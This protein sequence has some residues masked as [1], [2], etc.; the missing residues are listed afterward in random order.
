MRLILCGPY[1][2]VH[3]LGRLAMTSRVFGRRYNTGTRLISRGH[4]CGLSLIEEVIRIRCNKIEVNGIAL[5]LSPSQSVWKRLLCLTESTAAGLVLENNNT[6]IVSSRTNPDT[7]IVPHGITSIGVGAF[8]RD[9][10]CSELTRV[11]LS[12]TVTTIGMDAFTNCR[13]L[14]YFIQSANVTTIGNDAFAN[15][16][17]LVTLS[18][19]DGVTNI[20]AGAFFNCGNLQSLTLPMGLTAIPKCL[21]HSCFRLASF[22]LPAG[23]TEIPERALK[24]CSRLVSLIIPDTVTAI[25]LGALRHCSRLTSLDLP[26]GLTT[27]GA[28]A[29]ADCTALTSIASDTT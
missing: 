28:T 14:N 20:G 24:C 2:N 22:T 8:K 26:V 27:I 6:K 15:C 1:I 23:L 11:I 3:D 29:F 25:G 10:N 13:R 9:F 17:S 7:I 4:A 18:L 21:V 5:D 19:L 16:S 12:D